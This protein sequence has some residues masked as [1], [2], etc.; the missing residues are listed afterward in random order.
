MAHCLA[1]PITNNTNAAGKF[2]AQTGRLRRTVSLRIIAHLFGSRLQAS[3]SG[4]SRA[5]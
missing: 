4:Y 2:A 1:I 5:A 3:G